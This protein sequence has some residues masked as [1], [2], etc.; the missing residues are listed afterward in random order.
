MQ[1]T[2]N[3]HAPDE[4]AVEV[5]A[6]TNR[7]LASNVVTITTEAAHGLVVGDRVIIDVTSGA[8]AGVFDGAYVVASVADATHFTY[9]KTNANVGTAAATG[10]VSFVPEWTTLGKFGR[11]GQ[12]IILSNLGAGDISYDFTEPDLHDNVA[13]LGFTIAAGDRETILF[14]GVLYLSAD[15]DDTDLRYAVV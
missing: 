8:S 2:L 15:A 13:D 14:Q 7:V 12:Q 10:T 4:E 5:A 3:V 9:A 6:I 11:Q 1:T